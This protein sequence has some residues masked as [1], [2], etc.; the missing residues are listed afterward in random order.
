MINSFDD[1]QHFINDK[2]FNRIFVLG[3]KKSFVSSG[4]EK[5]IQKIVLKKKIK[6]FLNNLRYRFLKNY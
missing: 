4:A 3:G 2:S 1:I 6:F 5:L